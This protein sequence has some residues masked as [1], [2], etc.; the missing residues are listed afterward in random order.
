VSGDNTTRTIRT[1]L[2]KTSSAGD[3]NNLSKRYNRYPPEVW[4][5][6]YE[7]STYS[8]RR[9]RRDESSGTRSDRSGNLG[10]SSGS[11]SSGS[12]NRGSSG[13]GSSGSVNRGSSGSSGSSSTSGRRTKRYNSQIENNSS[14]NKVILNNQT[15]RNNSDYNQKSNIKSNTIRER[16][17]I[18]NR[19]VGSYLNRTFGKS[20]NNVLKRN[21]S[22]YTRYESN[23]SRS[24]REFTNSRRYSP[25][26][27]SEIRSNFSRGSSPSSGVSISKQGASNNRSSSSSSSRR[28]KR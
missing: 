11:G 13:S 12:V 2:T 1:G 3:V 6:G 20:S 26:G 7:S 16:V 21:N 8:E 27:G 5:L 19:A 9:T 24:I 18:I 15:I 25:S 22:N 4:E 14:N 10:R 23:S 28:E 17:E